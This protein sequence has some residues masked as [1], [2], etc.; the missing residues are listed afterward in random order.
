MGFVPPLHPLTRVRV[1]AW[2]FFNAYLILWLRNGSNMNSVTPFPS[3]LFLLQMASF[4][5][6]K[7]TSCPLQGAWEKRIL[8]LHSWQVRNH[9]HENKYPLIM[10]MKCWLNHS[11]D[12]GKGSLQACFISQRGKIEMR[13]S[14]RKL[15]A[16][17]NHPFRS[18][19]A[20]R[21]CSVMAAFPFQAWEE[22]WSYCV[23]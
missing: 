18:F 8:I 1:A 10:A 4:P 2:F 17:P 13:I 7:L 11:S 9:A 14:L 6:L 22:D 5:W 20:N 12:N 21:Y 15:S 16:P 19:T 23:H 3:I